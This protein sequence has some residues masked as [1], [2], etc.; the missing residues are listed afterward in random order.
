MRNQNPYHDDDVILN[1]VRNSKIVLIIIMMVV[2]CMDVMR[3]RLL[4]MAMASVF[5]NND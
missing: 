4:K 5:G 1:S 2:I 3:K